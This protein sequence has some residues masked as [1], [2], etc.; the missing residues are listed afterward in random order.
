[1]GERDD[2]LVFSYQAFEQLVRRFAGGVPQLLLRH[3][4]T[5]PLAFQIEQLR[6]A[7]ALALRFT[8]AII[9]QMRVGKSTLLNALIGRRLA[10][11]GVTETTATINWFRYGSG[12]L[13]HTFRVHWLDGSTED[14]PLR[15][16][17]EWIGNSEHATR[18]RA[19][20]FFA[21]TEFLQTANIVDTPGTRSVLQSHEATTQGFLAEKLE[22][23]TLRYGGRADAVLYA[24]NPV[25]READR[26][27]LQL[28]GDRTRL[29]GASAYNS[30]AVVQKWE[31]LG[32]DLLAEAAH[33]CARLRE[34]LQGKVS[35]V[36]QTSGLLAMACLEVGAETWAQLA[37]LARATAPEALQELLLSPEDFCEAIAGAALDRQTRA[38][39]RKSMEWPALR[40]TLW[41]AQTQ[42][43][44]DGPALRQA[45]WEASGLDK[46]KA[47][48]Q[49][50][51]FAL[52]G[53]IQAS[54]VLRKAWDPCTIALLRL[55]EVAERRRSDQALGRQALER[56]RQLAPKEPML[57]PVQRYV[58]S[59]L[60]EVEHKIHQVEQLRQEL[61]QMKYR[62]EDSFR[63]LDADITSLKALEMLPEEE[64]TEEESAELRRLFGETGPEVWRRLGLSSEANL[65]P[66][67][68]DRVW[69]M[70]EHW[71]RRRARASGA[72]RDISEHAV[73]RLS[74]ILKYLEEQEDA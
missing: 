44:D 49:R 11:T 51:F 68:V 5:A 33:K 24:I 70:H 15:E 69:A 59:S 57:E 50:R 4:A 36:L 40:F 46:L 38:T 41:L 65:T 62:A 73:N 13:C 45:V 2:S 6:L 28:F 66:S 42:G 39:L 23:E 22:A 32:P 74:L 25:G 14:R 20:D 7:D 35:E 1:M 63:L 18:T 10:P 43:F 27:L 67:A 61:D 8:V 31:H 56:L 52:A 71:A 12:D 9:G 19:L 3:P 48:L 60:G 54:T 55:R 29:P 26:D 37:T 64:V 47:V 34:Q 17:S 72:L 53:L 58:S 21:D 16:V 30:I